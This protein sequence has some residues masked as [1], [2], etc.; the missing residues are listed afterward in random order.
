MRIALGQVRIEMGNK[1][2]NVA[3]VLEAVARAGEAKCE[4]LVLPECCLAG[5]L[6]PAAAA[7]A[8]PIPGAFTRRLS[9]LAR[10]HCMAIAIGIEEKGETGRIYNTALL[11]DQAGAVILRHRKINEL[12]LARSTYS[13]GTSL[14]VGELCG[15]PVALTICADSWRP[16]VTDALYLMGARIIFSPSAWAVES[17]GEATN[18][19]W[20]TETYRQ[21]VGNRD[22]FI[23][24]PNGVG[25]VTQGPWKGRVLQG[26]SLV[27][28]PG[29]K[30]LLCGPTAEPA[31]LQLRL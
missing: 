9:A 7:C 16:E 28:G 20:I 29:G 2:A 12:A 25:A 11:I 21:R 30:T 14:E 15:V 1:R 23:I 27:I 5:W 19:S 6:S 22:L 17:G 13:S 4:V 31:L 18:L 3:A 24:A 10:K 8:E 26:N